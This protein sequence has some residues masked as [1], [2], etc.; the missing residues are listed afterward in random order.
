MFRFIIFLFVIGVLLTYLS[1]MNHM[2]VTVKF[3]KDL[4]FT[5]PLSFWIISL[6]ILGVFIGYIL[7]AFRLFY[8]GMKLSSKEK[9][10]KEENEKKQ[11]MLDALIGGSLLGEKYSQQ[12]ILQSKYKRDPWLLLLLG[13]FLR[14]IGDLK[15]AYDVH[16]KLYGTY[17]NEGYFLGEIVEDMVANGKYEEAVLIAKGKIE[18]L[19]S[20]VLYVLMDESEK[21]GNYI[22]A[23]F[24][25]SFLFK[26]IKDSFIKDRLLVYEMMELVR[27][28]DGAKLK[29]FL[30]SNAE[31]VPFAISA[32]YNLPLADA[33]D[34]I[35]DGYKKTGNPL[36]LFMLVKKITEPGGYSPEKVINFISS[37]GKEDIAKEILAY[38]YMELGMYENALEVLNGLDFKPRLLDFVSRVISESKGELRVAILYRD[39][40]EYLKERVFKFVC[41]YCGSSFYEV[42]LTCGSCNRIAFWKMDYGL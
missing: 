8:L 6:L 9:L 22:N 38:A 34:V 20:P 18:S 4:Y 12:A 31:L 29:K 36:Y 13:R 14:K 41:P 2:P 37:Y 5:M 10:L 27:L 26:R 40:L 7:S 3:Y 24:F 30:K 32:F 1:V 23:Q 33:Q 25:G 17:S 16:S 19:P 15:G 28:G 21:R 35:M 11:V 39:L 42:N